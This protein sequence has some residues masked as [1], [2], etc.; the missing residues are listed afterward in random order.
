M[1]SPGYSS[2]DEGR[3]YRSNSLSSNPKGTPGQNILMKD[4]LAREFG[5]SG[6][7]IMLG[8]K[9]NEDQGHCG[10]RAVRS[11]APTKYDRLIA[12]AK[13]VPAATTVV[14]Y[15]CDETSLRGPIEAAEAGII[16]PIL[17]GPAAKISAVARGLG[18]G[19]RSF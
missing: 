17:V 18:L 6:E 19:H 8:D 2:V 5:C 3:K 7:V 16:V 4:P 14:V 11:A 13:E 12:K 15:P 1:R 10:D 9:D